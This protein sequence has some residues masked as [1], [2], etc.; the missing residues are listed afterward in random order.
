MKKRIFTL[1]SMLLV[2]SL[3]LTACFSSKP[4]EEK[5]EETPSNQQTEQKKEPKIIK[6]NSH[7][8]P[9]SLHP[10]LA[11]GTHD[12]LPLDHL[13]EGL[14]KRD[15]NGKFVA[16]MAKEWKMSEDGKNW[17]FTLRDGIKWSNGDPLTAQ[18][19]EFAWK[20]CLAPASASEYAWQLYYL[21]G[22]EAYNTSKE[23]DAAKLKAL[24]DAVG[25]KA[26]D[27]KT[28]EVKLVQPVPYFLE[29][30]AFYTYY[31][32]N[33][34]VQEANANWYTEASSYVSN[35]AF[36]LTEWNHKAN[37]KLMKN[38]NYYDKDKVKLDGV[39]FALV[40]DLNTA[41]QMYQAGE[42]DI[43][44]DLPKDVV[45]KLK[46]EKNPELTIGS[47][48]AVY[49]YRFNN[50]KKPFSNVKVRKALAMAI[51]RATIVEQVTQG[52][53]KPVYGVVPHGIPDE[54]G[55]DFRVNAGEFFKE[56]VEE[57]KKLL[58][59]GLKEEGMDKL[60]FKI[61]YNTNEG[62]KKI[63]EAIQEMWRKNLGVEVTLENMEFQIKI[64][65]E[66]ALDYEVS[67]AGWIGDYVD[68]MTFL[69]LWD[70]KSSQNDTGW[71]NAKY[72]EFISKAKVEFE[73]AKRMQY[74][75][76][77]E[78][79]MMPDMPIMPI[80]SY[81]RPYASKPYVKGIFKPAN[82]DI[83]VHYADIVK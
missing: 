73:P 45:A 60:S 42:L 5:K 69:D 14:T 18:D 83:Q 9:G 81:T 32:V 67:R 66:D 63:A 21:E 62:H 54:T 74:M 24:E 10:G 46:A 30:C 37:L 64:D 7:S 40:D 78:K 70:S 25:V 77:A 26:K 48:L 56:D 55:G 1:V 72:D 17:T 27:E 22:A 65:R 51:D 57:A 50:T 41:W 12:S 36:K 6:M 11:Q 33:K 82:R 4:A 16:G 15:P 3:M 80:Y 75:R 13:F 53:E 79:V 34:K 23:T 76:E 20:Y 52:G 68:P 61:I 28:L 49:F 31:P 71:K 29:L 47:E 35:G 44:F 19:F 58:A 43:E 8:E 38:E 39:N 59:E 2:L